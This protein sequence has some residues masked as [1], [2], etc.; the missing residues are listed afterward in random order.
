MLLNDSNYKIISQIDGYEKI[1]CILRVAENS[2]SEKRLITKMPIEY[3]RVKEDYEILTGIRS[4]FLIK[5]AD[6]FV[7]IQD[8]FFFTINTYEVSKY[9]ASVNIT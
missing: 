5:F 8:N 4:Q 6:L 2:K 7:H 1:E 9:I 3:K